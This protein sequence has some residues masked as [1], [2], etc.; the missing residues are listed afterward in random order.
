MTE[1]NASLAGLR[2]EL[3]SVRT[4]RENVFKG[5][6]EAWKRLGSTEDSL[7]D[8]KLGNNNNNNKPFWRGLK[9]KY[10]PLIPFWPYA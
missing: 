5:L 6:I 7:K 1:T 10:K 2:K 9:S 3:N 4:E 8:G